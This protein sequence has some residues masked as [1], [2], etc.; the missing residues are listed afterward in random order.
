MPNKPKNPKS[1]KGK[2]KAAPVPAIAKKEVQKKPTNPLIE[3]RPRK[4]GIGQSIQPKR[5]LSHFMKWPKYVTLQRKHAIMRKRIKMPPPINQ[6]RSTLDRDNTKTVL[7]FLRKHKGPSPKE[8]R[9]QLKEQAAKRVEGKPAE[10]GA[11]KP[12]TLIAGFRQVTQVIERGRAQLVV[13]A[14]D[15][16]PIEVVLFLPALCR[17]HNVPYCI[18]KSKARLGQIVG[19]KTC[20]SVALTD[21]ASG[22]RGALGKIQETVRTDFNNRADEIR[23]HF[24]GGEMSRKSQAKKARVE[25]TKAKEIAQKLS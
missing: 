12:P 3:S 2:K 21:V 11:K 22:D 9:A 1:K 14:H 24:G 4:Y 13:I 17:R 7:E 5:D 15:V 23:R 19:R 18:V 6:F 8:K 16:E 10:T 25:K 20:T